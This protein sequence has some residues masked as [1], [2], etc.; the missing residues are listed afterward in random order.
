MELKTMCE[1]HGG[2]DD[3]ISLPARRMRKE[4]WV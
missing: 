1:N 4:R 2:I 3:V